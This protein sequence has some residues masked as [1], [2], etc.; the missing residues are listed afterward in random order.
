MT[1]VV[2]VGLL[3]ATVIIYCWAFAQHRRAVPAAWTRIDS[4]STGICLVLVT[5]LAAGICFLI[6]GLIAPRETLAGMTTASWAALAVEGV[7]ILLVVP[8]MMRMARKAL[9]VSSGSVTPFPPHGPTGTPPHVAG[10]AGKHR[11]AA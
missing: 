4:L 6:A 10:A 8:P 5:T 1:L 7:A 3:A 9:P 2:G 11:K